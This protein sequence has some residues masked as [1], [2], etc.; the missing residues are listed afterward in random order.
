MTDMAS[1]VDRREFLRRVGLAAAAFPA[2]GAFLAACSS[3]PAPDAPSV[4][5]AVGAGGLGPTFQSGRP[6]ERGTILR[7]YEWKDYLA[8][9]V[10]RSFERR[11]RDDGVTVQVDSF[12][13][14]DEAIA[15]LADPATEYDIFFPTVDVLDGLIAARLLRPLDHGQL[16]NLGNLWP[17]FRAADGPFYDPGARYTVPYTVYSS[18][19]GWRH[20]RVVPT[21]AP[22]A[23]TEP[24]GVFWNETYRGRV[25]MYDDY[26]EALSLALQRRG[27][28]DLRA[29]TDDELA[30]A[31]ADLGAAV[32]DVGVKFTADGAWCGLADGEFSVH[33]AWSG[34]ILTARRYAEEQGHPERVDQ[35]RYWSPPTGKVVGCDLMAICARGRNPELAHA[36]ID[37][38][39]QV[40]VGMANFVWNGYQPP[41]TALTAEA[42]DAPSFE[43]RDAVP[44]HLRTAILSEDDVATGQMLVGFG[45]SERARW[46][47]Q[48]NRVVGD[49]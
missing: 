38:L 15:V 3:D 46:L 12:S 26:V 9:D 6:V 5:S 47:A 16:P 28:A 21:D 36:F 48:W 49:V 41:L 44:E 25:G 33:Q 2:A 35:L 42:F 19:V 18:G 20:D 43:W 40:D 45:P 29:A 23:L 24:F 10:L 34:D 39:L 13:H 1:P 14:V 37:H 17:W 22:D 7:V 30:G 8:R 32:R 11:F 31:A 27:V 4:R